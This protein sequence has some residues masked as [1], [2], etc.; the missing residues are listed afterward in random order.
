MT[1]SPVLYQR[2]ADV[3]LEPVTDQISR[4]L[5][6]GQRMMLAHVYLKKGA[7]VPK[8]QHHNEQFTYILEGALR[9]WIGDDGAEVIDVRAGEVL[10]IPS[11]VWHK[12]EALE[13]T[14]DVDIFDPPREDWLN[15]TDAYFHQK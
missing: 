10:H 6:T 8:H 15:K 4:K 3:P 2:W 12:A 1:T 14:L 7:V 9:F 13:D 5:I 11:N